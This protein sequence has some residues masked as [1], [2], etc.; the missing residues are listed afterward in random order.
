MPSRRGIEDHLIDEPG[1]DQSNADRKTPRPL[2]PIRAFP[3]FGIAPQ[4]AKKADAELEKIA[5]ELARAKTIED[6]NDKMAET[7]FGEELSLIAAQ[8]VA[9]G[10]PHE[11]ANDGELALFDTN[12]GTKAM[13][14]VSLAG[15][16]CAGH[17]QEPLSMKSRTWK[18]RCIPASMVAK[19][20][21]IFPRRSD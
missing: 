21:W 4:R 1:R 18:Y 8:V 2:P 7:L 9:A 3:R 5:A 20:A 13:A 16:R 10:A 11:S 17:V 6:V 15:G 14:P 12:A 19:P